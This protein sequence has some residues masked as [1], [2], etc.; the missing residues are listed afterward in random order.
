M[1]FSHAIGKKSF[2][3]LVYLRWWSGNN[4]PSLTSTLM[5]HSNCG[6]VATVTKGYIFQ[7]HFLYSFH[8]V[9][10]TIFEPY[11]RSLEKRNTSSTPSRKCCNPFWHVFGLIATCPERRWM[12]TPNAVGLVW[13][14]KT[15]IESLNKEG[16]RKKERGEKTILSAV[17]KMSGIFKINASQCKTNRHERSIKFLEYHPILLFPYQKRSACFGIE[18]RRNFSPLSLG[19]LWVSFTLQNAARTQKK[20]FK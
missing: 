17:W 6:E 15:R 12:H 20:M 19:S 9:H 3:V 7:S 2:I 8:E 18:T 13:K 10:L 5:C 1:L 16:E 11:K 14:E 4:E